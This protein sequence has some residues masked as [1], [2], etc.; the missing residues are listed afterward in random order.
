MMERR[1]SVLKPDTERRGSGILKEKRD[2]KSGP[3]PKKETVT[4]KNAPPKQPDMFVPTTTSDI[5]NSV[6]DLECQTILSKDKDERTTKDL[7]YVLNRV[8]HFNVFQ[9]YL[10]IF[11][12]D[13]LRS[14]VK[15]VKFREVPENTVL[16][17]QGEIAVNCFILF[18]GQFEVL[19]LEDSIEYKR[20]G[21]VPVGFI[22]G[23]K[24]LNISKGKRGAT[25]KTTVR[26]HVGEISKKDYET[27]KMKDIETKETNDKIDFLK[28]IKLFINC[29]R[30]YL[31]KHTYNYKEFIY[32]GGQTVIK[33]GD[34]LENKI[35]I[36]RRGLFSVH[37][38]TERS[39]D[40]VFDLNY[41]AEINSNNLQRFSES[42]LHEIKGYKKT[43]DLYRLLVL[44]PG[45]YFGDVEYLQGLDNSTFTLKCT[46]KDSVLWVYSRKEFET[47]LK[48]FFNGDLLKS[49]TTQIEDKILEYK[50]RFIQL[51]SY[52][53]NSEHSDENKLNTEIMTRVISD[54]KIKSEKGK[55]DKISSPNGKSNVNA[56]LSTKII[57]SEKTQS[58]S[59][60]TD[61]LSSSAR[62]VNVNLNSNY[63]TISTNPKN[64]LQ[65]RESEWKNRNDFPEIDIYTKHLGSTADKNKDKIEKY[66]T[67]K[68]NSKKTDDKD[69]YKSDTSHRKSLSNLKIIVKKKIRNDSQS[70]DK[71][72]IPSTEPLKVLENE[73][74]EFSNPFVLSKDSRLLPI[75]NNE[76]KTPI[77][78][79]NINIPFYEKNKKTILKEESKSKYY[80]CAEVNKNYFLDPENFK[81]V[82]SK[83]YNFIKENNKN[84]LHK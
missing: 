72:T 45:Q 62:A 53:K 55:I 61:A 10:K 73:K 80:E 52:I 31:Q 70:Q 19:I 63:N 44:G 50:K 71:T 40:V 16:M 32:E 24:A 4:P 33:Q 5:H 9:K 59:N 13:M 26:S 42:R 56:D 28:S 11:D 18:H 47:N 15:I 82:L 29:D 22:C 14:I 35:Y 58:T 1:K 2:S 17:K 12:W 64:S 76:I 65:F 41:F 49:L 21:L 39:L 30:S 7:D 74:K 69:D 43:M 83:K 36:V 75:Y 46:Q 34:S 6:L 67:S 79:M 23:E 57:K 60:T 25:I 51:K 37:F 66:V 38:Q 27:Y 48:K 84:F 77:I 20:I 81:S 78:N 3:V 68:F 8:K 54:N